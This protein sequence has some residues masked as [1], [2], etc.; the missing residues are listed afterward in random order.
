[1]EA[2][3]LLVRI[4]DAKNR[5]QGSAEVA[6]AGDADLSAVYARYEAALHDNVAL[7]FDDLLLRTVRLLESRPEVLS[8]V[9][10]RYRWLSVDE[11]QDVNLA[12]VRLL[13]LLT[14]GGANL[15]VIGD[16]DQAIYGFRGADRSYFLAFQQDY[17]T[18]RLLR[19][20]DNYRSTQLILDAAVQVLA[21]QRA[22][23]VPP[24]HAVAALAEF[25]EQVRLD[26]HRAA[27]D[28]AEA[29]YVVH[30]IEQMVGGTSYFSVDSGRL[31][32]DASAEP[33]G[34]ERAFGDFAVLYRLG[35]QSRALIEAFDRSGIP[36]Q[37]A[38][39][40]VMLRRASLRPLTACSARR[41]TWPRC[42]C[43]QARSRFGA[44]EGCSPAC[45]N[46]NGLATAFASAGWGRW[47]S[48]QRRLALALVLR[49]TGPCR[50][51]LVRRRRVHGR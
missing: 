14:A 34:A 29:E 21:A 32:G 19:L 46:L 5:L 22:E 7:D 49:A 6:A 24:L 10:A 35:A 44:G 47:V 41:C 42:W 23:Q 13:R 18:A 27:T 8:A 17:P 20:S 1:M 15:C 3:R 12:Q 9:H 48:R 28:R 4:S 39:Y 40:P 37:C 25:S 26:T 2:E 30:Q 16:P 33:G 51:E 43:R 50:C 45:I 11:Y 36:Y 31:D 38:G